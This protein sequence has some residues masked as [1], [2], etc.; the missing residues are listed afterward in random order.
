MLTLK[1]PA[2]INWFLHVLSRRDDGYHNILSVMQCIGLYD[3][4]TF[5]PSAEVSLDSSLEIPPEENLVFRAAVLLRE[6]AGVSQGVHITLV[7]EIPMGAGLGGGSSDAASVL[8][9]LNTLWNLHLDPATL[10][11]IGEKLGSDVPFF[12]HCP[13]AL[14]EGRGERVTPLHR[15]VHG[16][17][18]LVKPPVH[19]STKWAYEELSARGEL[20]RAEEKKD[21]N[22][23]SHENSVLEAFGIP[24]SLFRND[25]EDVMQERFPIIGELKKQL[26]EEG[27]E[28]ALMSGSGPTLA[29]FFR[30][31]E[32]ALHAMK[33][34]SEHWTKVV[35]TLV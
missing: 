18:L 12:F 10:E 22:L 7:K 25:F 1:A 32:R 2:K 16:Y 20:T 14:V 17:L 8:T 5:E 30:E 6:Q 29:G 31:R 35:P 11:R 19:V 34:F 23:L 33:R 3:T 4:L 21:N 26:L 9:G 15:S 24:E 28:P 13:V 27:A